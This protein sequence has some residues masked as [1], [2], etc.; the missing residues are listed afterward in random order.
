LLASSGV[1]RQPWG[2]GDLAAQAFN[3]CGE[4]SEHAFLVMKVPMAPFIDQE[5][6]VAAVAKK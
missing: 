1:P 3:A 5:F 6:E 2:Y 4:K